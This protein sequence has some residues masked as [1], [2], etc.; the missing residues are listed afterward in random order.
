MDE[1]IGVSLYND[2]FRK[3]EYVVLLLFV[4]ESRGDFQALKILKLSSKLVNFEIEPFDCFWWYLKLLR[5]EF[6][7]IRTSIFAEFTSIYMLY[8]SQFV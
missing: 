2:I 8:L 6:K 7:R 3:T 4:K 5:N 1:V